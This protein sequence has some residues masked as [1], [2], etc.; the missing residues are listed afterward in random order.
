MKK[1]YPVFSFCLL[2]FIS[3]FSYSQSIAEKLGYDKDSK[4][5][6]IHADDVGVSHSVNSAT[7]KAFEKSGISSASIMVPC[8]W[9]PEI[10]DYVKQ[11]PQYDFGLHLTLTA[12]WKNYRWGGVLSAKE[13]P[14]LLDKNGFFYSTAEEV[15]IKANPVE[16]EQELRAQIDRAIAFGVKPTHLDSH[17]GSLFT[18]P[19]LFQVY[20]KV[21]AAY[22]IPVFIPMNA[23]KTFPELLQYIN[24]D[25]IPVDNYFMMQSNR[26]SDEWTTF[27]QNIVENLSPGLNEIIIHL[28][29]DNSEM[30][31]VTVDHP[32]YGAKWRQNDLN[33]V[34]SDEFKSALAKNNI[35]II[36]WKEIKDLLHSDY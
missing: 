24:E 17:M 14:S 27:Y 26:P 15:A 10:A 12:E 5:L 31:A 1:L 32:D 16:V 13:I 3:I 20:L 6:I 30:Q 7:I 18:T 33:T 9:F 22:K 28:A 36:S 23:V 34:L 11:H 4:L 8:P 21:G 25:Q 2:L 29:I 35:K 19:D